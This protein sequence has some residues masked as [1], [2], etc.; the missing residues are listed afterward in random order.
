MRSLL[1]RNSE[2]SSWCDV[3][4]YWEYK[5]RAFCFGMG[6][7]K[8]IPPNACWNLLFGL[9]ES[10]SHSSYT[11]YVCLGNTQTSGT[12]GSALPFLTRSVRLCWRVVP[13]SNINPVILDLLCMCFFVCS[14]FI[15]LLW[16][17]SESSPVNV[18]EYLKSLE[19]CW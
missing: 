4:F 16:F 19:K 8:Q 15:Y 6:V 11:S 17:K 7:L 1:C 14:F 18:A 5:E 10:E 3:I 9:R 2:K 13:L 12:L